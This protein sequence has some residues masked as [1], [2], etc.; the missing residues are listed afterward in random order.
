[1][2]PEER[3]TLQVGCGGPCSDVFLDETLATCSFP[4]GRESPF[5]SSLP[6]MR[7]DRLKSGASPAGRSLQYRCGF[8]PA[9]HHHHPFAVSSPAHIGVTASI[10]G[11][12]SR[13]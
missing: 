12:R 9:A 7:N 3:R 1:L 11:Q 4:T 5:G 2:A 8:S 10:D 13:T 6:A